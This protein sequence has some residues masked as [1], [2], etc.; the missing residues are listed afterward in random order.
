MTVQQEQDHQHMQASKLIICPSVIQPTFTQWLKN[1]QKT[2]NDEL[3]YSSGILLNET[4]N[5]AHVEV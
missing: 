1:L 2:P 3:K 4:I 5:L